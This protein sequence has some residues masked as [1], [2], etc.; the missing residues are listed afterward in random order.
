MPAAP[1]KIFL[2]LEYGSFLGIEEKG[3]ARPQP[4]TLVSLSAH[5]KTDRTPK[6][7]TI[8]ALAQMLL[9]AANASIEEP[10]D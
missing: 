1:F 4:P 8:Q 6:P 5:F 10:Q 9:L 3:T 2:C 7:E